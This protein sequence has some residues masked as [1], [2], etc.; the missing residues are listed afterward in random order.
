VKTHIFGGLAHEHES[1]SVGNDLGRVESLFEV[2]D[3]LLLVAVEDLLLRTRD[4]FAG[5]DALL[6]ER[7]QTP[8]EDGL[9]D[10]GDYRRGK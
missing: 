9:S 4:N 1:L 2:I 5:A 3:E 6:L 10:Q 8:S 7:R